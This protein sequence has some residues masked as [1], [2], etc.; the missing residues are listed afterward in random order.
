MGSSVFESG[1]TNERRLGN[2][3]MS[4][5]SCPAPRRP[6]DG[7][8]TLPLSARPKHH[9]RPTP[10]VAN[11]SNARPLKHQHWPTYSNGKPRSWRKPTRPAPSG[12]HTPPVH[13][14][15]Q[16]APATNS[17]PAA[18][19][20]TP[21]SAVTAEEWFD[22]HRADQTIEDQHR[23]ITDEHDLAVVAEQRDQARR[24]AQP[25]S[26]DAAESSLPDIREQAATEPKRVPR[27]NDNDWTRVPTADQTADSIT[28][29]QRALSEIRQ[30][31]AEDRHRE[32]DQARSRQLNHWHHDDRQA[33]RDA[34]RKDDR[35]LD[36]A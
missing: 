24:G 15:P 2:P 17:A 22:A 1:P 6:R 7:T 20:P 34:Q 33:E 36:R 4:P 18:S 25:E 29:A 30:R 13:A 11:S 27:G 16:T 21:T 14:P 3:T 12:T 35:Q 9:T 5:L 31:D 10:S 23:A 28:R 8:A 32:V 19:T 26:R